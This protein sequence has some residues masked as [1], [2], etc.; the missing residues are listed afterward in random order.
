MAPALCAGSPW[1]NS[2][3]PEQPLLPP[4]WLG[5]IWGEAFFAGALAQ[6]FARTSGIPSVVLLLATGL[7]LGHAGLN[8]IQPEQLSRGLEPVVG[9][10][11]ESGAFRRWP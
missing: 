10:L 11:V 2:L 6:L 3:P 9:L 8:W 1:S 4:E 7:M 5:L